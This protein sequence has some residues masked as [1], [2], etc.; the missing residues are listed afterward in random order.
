MGLTGGSKIMENWTSLTKMEL[1]SR[2]NL[3]GLAKPYSDLPADP[4]QDLKDSTNLVEVQ[5]VLICAYCVIILLGLVGNSLVIHVVIKFKSMRTVTNFF[6]ANLAVA[7]LLVNTLCLPFTL[8]YTLLGEWKLGP[9][10]CHLVPY[11]Q[12]LAVQVS[13]VTLTVIAL[14]RHRCIVYHLESKISKRISFLI[15]G[16]AW[17]GSAVLASPLAIFREYFSIELNQDLKMVVCAEAWPREGLVNFGTIYS[18]L[19]LLIQY[20]LPLV[21]I[22]YA[23][24]R[25][26]S[27]LKSHASPGAG[28]D[29]YHQRRRKTTKMLVCVVVVFAV[30]WLPFHIFQLVS[31]IDSKVMVLQEYKLI[32]TLFHVIAMCSTFANPLLYGWMNNNYRTAFLTAFRCEQRLDSIHPEVSPALKAK[33]N[34]EVKEDHCNGSPFSQPTSV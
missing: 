17:G 34:L 28:N 2:L 9:A 32:Y 6:I 16:V 1:Y 24:I 7:D 26:W 12:G 27:K 21:I 25:I 4:K 18:I 33:K 31:D 5:I 20:V 22:S 19:M 15:I 13:I 30:C 3:P 29:H 10:L 8:V 11:A 14:D 23:Y